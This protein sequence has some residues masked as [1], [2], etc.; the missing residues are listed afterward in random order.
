MQDIWCDLCKRFIWPL[1]GRSLQTE[2]WSVVDVV[3]YS[4]CHPV[5]WRVS[6][7][8]L[9][10]LRNFWVAEL[11]QIS[12]PF[13]FLVSFVC[14]CSQGVTHTHYAANF[15]PQAPKGWNYTFVNHHAQLHL[16]TYVI[17]C[18]SFMEWIFFF[19]KVTVS[20]CILDGLE[21]TM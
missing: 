20:L 9:F 1:R 4:W 19:F 13:F 21:L 3:A 17:H 5:D 6:S 15:L 2:S 8:A 12:S 7:H 18:S 11:V 14:L 10:R 16:Y